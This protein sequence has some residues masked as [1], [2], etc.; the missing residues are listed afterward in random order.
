[1]YNQLFVY[2]QR[3]FGWYTIVLFVGI[4]L[5]YYLQRDIID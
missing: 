3:S 5:R 4:L 2:L 1:M